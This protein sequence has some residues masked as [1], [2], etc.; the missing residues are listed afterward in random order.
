MN[1]YYKDLL[2]AA[3]ISPDGK[4][5]YNIVIKALD[6]LAPTEKEFIE[7]LKPVH[8][9]EDPHGRTSLKN[10]RTVSAVYRMNNSQIRGKRDQISKK[11]VGIIKEL[12]VSA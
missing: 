2:S 11:L 9:E 10:T 6:Y 5:G 7:L 3:H 8:L 12:A 1:K 4:Y